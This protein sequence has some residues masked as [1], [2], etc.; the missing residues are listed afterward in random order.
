MKSFL[1]KIKKLKIIKYFANS[2][3]GIK[4][5]NTINFYPLSLYINTIDNAGSISDDFCWRTDNGFQ[6]IFH[7]ADILNLFYDIKDSEF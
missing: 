1:K 7:Y 3:N 4:L 6:T 5:R 2:R